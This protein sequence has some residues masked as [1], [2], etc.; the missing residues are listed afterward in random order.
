MQKI[1]SNR[2]IEISLRQIECSSLPTQQSIERGSRA[3]STTC[4]KSD[5]LT[6]TTV[7]P[8]KTSHLENT[9]LLLNV[10]YYISGNLNE[11]NMDTYSLRQNN[12]TKTIAQ[13]NYCLFIS[14]KFKAMDHAF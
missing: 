12:L 7:G 3:R 10:C 11:L 4:R 1:V 6:K 13:I 14:M 5:K 2:L 9:L 8:E